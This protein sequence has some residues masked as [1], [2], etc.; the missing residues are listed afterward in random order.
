MRSSI[1]KKFI[2]NL[3][4]LPREELIRLI[5]LELSESEL[6][7]DIIDSLEDAHLVVDSD[8]NAVFYNEAF[9]SLF[10]KRRKKK[11]WE[12]EETLDSTISDK[13]ILAF[14]K[15]VLT[16]EKKSEKMDFTLERGGEAKTIRV[17][18]I[19]L[20]S[21]SVKYVD[22][23]FEDITEEIRREARLRRSESLASMTSM[24]AGIAHE[25]KNPL[26]AMMIHIQLMEKAINEDK[27]E[28]ES[29][30]KFLGVLNEEVERLNSIAVDFLFATK[31]MNAEPKL[32]SLEEVVDQLFEFITPEA[33]E[34]NISLKLE[35]EDF[36]PLLFIDKKLIYQAFLNIAQNSFQAMEGGG[37]LTVSINKDGDVVKVVFKD[38]G[39]GM[40]EK[41]MSHIFEPYFTTKA[42]G[43]GLGLTTVW[44]IMKEHGGDISVKS[45]KGKGCEMTLFFPIPV[46]SRKALEEK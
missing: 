7:M 34:K 39:E 32:S 36:L 30:L 26:A 16:G 20:K 28:K 27:Y 6:Y 10:P 44:K 38:T 15:G 23:V 46:S 24:A 25:I 12:K 35:K 17:S 41:M 40:D 3:D 4:A 22:V 21:S 37:E 13:D 11:G 42:K 5:K 43:T 29:F 8:L 45:E 1:L 31:P 33:K 19:E 14:V 2:Q 18:F 9:R